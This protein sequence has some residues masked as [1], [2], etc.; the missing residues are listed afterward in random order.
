MKKIIL[1]L[2]VCVVLIIPATLFAEIKKEEVKFL[3]GENILKTPEDFSPIYAKDFV[4][5]NPEIVTI[6][7]EENNNT[8]AYVNVFGGV[9]QNFVL[10]QNKTYDIVCKK[11]GDIKWD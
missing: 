11:E 5:L 9:G 2:L 8:L 7:F 10:M 6:T 3:E 1:V 4:K